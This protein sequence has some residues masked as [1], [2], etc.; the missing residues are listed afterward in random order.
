[1]TN[2]RNLTL[3]ENDMIK[4]AELKKLHAR[5][6]EESN[7]IV[8]PAMQPTFFVGL[9]EID[10]RQKQKEIKAQVGSLSARLAQVVIE[11][12]TIE[13]NYNLPTRMSSPSGRYRTPANTPRNFKS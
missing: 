11:I 6:Q 5:L 1:M 12:E 8:K 13:K 9:S 7:A 3:Q 10:R 2:N 4:L